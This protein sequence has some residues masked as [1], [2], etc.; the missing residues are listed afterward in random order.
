MGYG[1]AK[2][3]Q[4]VWVEK[5]LKMNNKKI[6]EAQYK[7]ALKIV[8]DYKKQ[9]KEAKPKICNHFNIDWNV[10][11]QRYICPNCG[12]KGEIYIKK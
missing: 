7:S 2:K 4:N 5:H 9:L 12:F 8:S 10:S 11:E 3:K 6:T 1:I